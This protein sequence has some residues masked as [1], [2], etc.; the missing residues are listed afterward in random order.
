MTT[1]AMTALWLGLLFVSVACD[2]GATAYLKVAGDRI[3]G[4]GFFGTAVIGVVVFA[5]SI[6]TFGYSMKVGPSYLAT[7]GIWAVGVY[8]ANA[9]VGVVAFGDPFGV[10]TALGV[11]LA[12][13]TVVLL[14]PA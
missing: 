8:A 13:V 12:C 2:V 5:P 6:I 3:D 7:V 4:L 1:S 11:V 9:V 10:R 14:N